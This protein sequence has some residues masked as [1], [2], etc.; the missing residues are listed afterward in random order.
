[1]EE[2]QQKIRHVHCLVYMERGVRVWVVVVVPQVVVGGRGGLC[3][4]RKST[5]ARPYLYSV[6]AALLK[7]AHNPP[8]LEY[9][10]VDSHLTQKRTL[11]LSQDIRNLFLYRN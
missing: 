2:E 3:V 9:S 6:V 7:R 1:M 11:S 8:S 10:L 5:R 4:V